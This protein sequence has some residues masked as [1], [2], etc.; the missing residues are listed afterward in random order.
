MRPFFNIAPRVVVYAHGTPPPAVEEGWLAL[1]QF[2]LWPAAALDSPPPAQSHCDPETQ[3]STAPSRPARPG[4]TPEPLQQAAALQPARPGA[5]PEPL[6]Q[7]GALQP[8]RPGLGRGTSGSLVTPRRRAVFGDGSH[9]TT[10]LCAGAVD[11]LCR[12]RP[13]MA[14]LDVGTGTG[15]LARIARARGARLVVATDIDPSAVV[16]AKAH[17]ELDEVGLPGGMASAPAFAGVPATAVVGVSATAVRSGV[18]LANIHFGGEAPDCWGAR[19]DLV[20]ANILEAPLHALAPAL[21]RALLPGGMLLI[22]GF[23]RP[24]VPALRLAYETAGL[25]SAGDFTLDHWV[26][27]KFARAV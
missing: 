13:G 4:A 9:A 17:A 11:L 26:L 3:R 2:D 20:V 6:Q 18:A 15:I 25:Q 16:C 1:A 7:A 22:S 24:Q 21:C 8:A 23:T 19:F 10:R 5:T 27:L 12:Q 14:V